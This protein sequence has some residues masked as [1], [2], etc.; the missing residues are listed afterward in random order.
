M[1][2]TPRAKEMAA[3]A[4]VNEK[5]KEPC[6]YSKTSGNVNIDSDHF[7]TKKDFIVI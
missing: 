4:F 7:Q 1:Y 5:V 6:M 3:S 2:D